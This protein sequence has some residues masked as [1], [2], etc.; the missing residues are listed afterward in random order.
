LRAAP[1]TR[2]GIGLYEVMWGPPN[3]IRSLG[4]LAREGGARAETIAQREANEGMMR[5]TREDR[6]R[7]G[8]RPR[9]DVDRRWI[10]PAGCGYW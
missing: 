7:E 2:A 9:A 3:T 4:R 1:A 10:A 5:L 8:V 6:A